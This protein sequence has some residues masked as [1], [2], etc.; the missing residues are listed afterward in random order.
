M[1]LGTLWKAPNQHLPAGTGGSCV[2]PTLSLLFMGGGWERQPTELQEQ[3]CWFFN[4]ALPG[5]TFPGT[6]QT[7]HTPSS[8]PP[9]VSASTDIQEIKEKLRAMVQLSTTVV[10]GAR[11]CQ[12]PAPFQPCVLIPQAPGPTIW[13]CAPTLYFLGCF[14]ALGELLGNTATDV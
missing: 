2:P 5:N 8:L 10:L 14:Q 11:Q 6:P 9:T 4:Q 1:G 7:L 13:D 3:I 12:I